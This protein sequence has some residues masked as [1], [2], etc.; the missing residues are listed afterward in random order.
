MKREERL[1]TCTRLFTRN[2]FLETKA[3]KQ[4]ANVVNKEDLPKVRRLGDDFGRLTAA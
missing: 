1:A 3:A 4:V 2:D